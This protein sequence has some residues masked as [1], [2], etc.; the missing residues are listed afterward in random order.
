MNDAMRTRARSLGRVLGWVVPAAI[1]V[2]CIVVTGVVLGWPRWIG[3]VVG[4]VALAGLVA[5]A[6]A[7]RRSIPAARLGT[8]HSALVVGTAV[9]AATAAV[10]MYAHW[11]TAKSSHDRDVSAV[12]QRSAEL[13]ELMTTVSP[14]SRDQYMTRLQPLL[15]EGM[16]ASLK[17]KVL[18]PM[19]A[20]TKQKGLV[21]AV[22]VQ[23]I[24]DGIASVIVV[25]EP[26]QD[27]VTTVS[28]TAQS[29]DIVLWLFLI[30]EDGQ[31][32]LRNLAPMTA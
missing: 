26:T 16:A 22:G 18:D 20:T 14:D 4:A 10:V 11:G 17:A 21:R 6:G 24:V 13:A 19:P 8:A 12:A 31:W 25:V 2:G 7:A 1:T 3:F 30:E 27:G 32:K 23:G 28:D 5:L 29:R 15:V 9:V